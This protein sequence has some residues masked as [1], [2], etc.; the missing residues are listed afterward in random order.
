MKAFLEEAKIVLIYI[1]FSE[2]LNFNHQAYCCLS[3]F[4]QSIMLR[5]KKLKNSQLSFNKLM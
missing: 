3:I 5:F 1:F 4:S 2:W